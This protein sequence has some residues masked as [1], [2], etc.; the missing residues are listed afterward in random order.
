[1][2]SNFA[3]FIYILQSM[4]FNLII[5]TVKQD[6]SAFGLC[7]GNCLSAGCASTANAVRKHVFLQNNFFKSKT[8]YLALQLC[9]HLLTIYS[10]CPFLMLTL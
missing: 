9:F 3:G 5:I 2:S 10:I 6:L 7:V 4:A 1:M 8:H